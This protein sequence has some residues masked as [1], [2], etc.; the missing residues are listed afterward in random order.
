MPL[1]VRVIPLE[2]E[3]SPGTFLVNLIGA[4]IIGAIS[5]V[6]EVN[7]PLTESPA[8][9]RVG[10]CGGFTTFSTLPLSLWA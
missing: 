7:P 6:W 1:F 10:L 4:I 9:L 3:N 8:A 2:R 5:A